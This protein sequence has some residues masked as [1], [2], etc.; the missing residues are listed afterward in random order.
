MGPSRQTANE[1]G[2]L[3]TS[4]FMPL[5]DGDLGWSVASPVLRI[6]ALVSWESPPTKLWTCPPH[7]AI[8]SY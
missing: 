4:M 5:P 2:G 8:R 3:K 7:A 6:E 1:S